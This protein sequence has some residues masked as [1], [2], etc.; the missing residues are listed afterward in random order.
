M[1]MQVAFLILAGWQV[2]WQRLQC[3]SGCSTPTAGPGCRW[4]QRNPAYGPGAA[5]ENG[6]LRRTSFTKQPVIFREV[7]A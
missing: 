5:I 4:R 7:Q 1:S 2:A 6:R 3:K